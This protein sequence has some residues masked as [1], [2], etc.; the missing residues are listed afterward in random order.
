VEIKTTTLEN[1]FKIENKKN[2]V[3]ATGTGIK[4]C[5][6]VR[7]YINGGGR[8]TLVRTGKR[9]SYKVFLLFFF[10][11]ILLFEIVGNKSF[12]PERNEKTPLFKL[13]FSRT[14]L[15]ASSNKNVLFYCF[16][17]VDR[18]TLRD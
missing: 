10:F 7:V 13:P 8:E 3:S 1:L 4:Y 16:T 14:I 15:I 11:V 2:N 12:K 9:F 18:E 6:R 17:R 5:A